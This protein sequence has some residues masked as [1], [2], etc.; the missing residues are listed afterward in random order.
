MA[1]H[2]FLFRL[3]LNKTTSPIP[4][5]V[6][7]PATAEP[8]LIAPSRKS[9]VIRIEAAQFG[10]SPSSAVRNGWKIVPPSR[11]FER[12]S[13]PIPSIRTFRTALKTMIKAKSYNEWFS[14]GL[15]IPW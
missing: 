9:C 14:A 10:I 15:I 8:K 6:H 3:V 11:T 12:D 13:S 2:S 4:A 1:K 5:P 7:R